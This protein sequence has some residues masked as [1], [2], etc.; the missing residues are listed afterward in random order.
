[1]LI[2]DLITAKEIAS[3]YAEVP[4]NKLPYLGESLFPAVKQDGIDIKWF[5]SADGLPL[6]ITPSNYD[7][8]ATL[9]DRAG[10]ASVETEMPFFREAMRI[11]EKERQEL[12]KFATQPTSPYVKTIVARLY[13]DVAKL[14]EGVK[15]QAE[16]MRMQLLSTG[17]ISIVANGVAYDYDY[18]FNANH[19]KTLTGTAKWSDT[20]NADPYADIKLALDTVEADTGVRPDT[21]IMTRKSFD[22]LVANAK[23]KENLFFVLG[24]G[25]VAGSVV[26]T[27]EMVKQYLRLRLQIDVIIYNKKFMDGSTAKS[28]FPDD[29]VTFIPAQSKL[30]N[31]YFGVTPEESDLLSGNTD[32]QVAIVNNGVAVTTFKEVHPVNV[33]TVVSAIFL[34]SFEGIETTYILTLA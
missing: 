29:V 28:Y 14:V 24:G 27:D 8:K 9:R 31:T 21:A 4:S 16:R 33:V 3:F 15:V 32:A 12:N 5:K 34:P 17:K 23:I 30:G 10:F 6:A 26:V 20:A 2:F 22:Y 11:G 7:A 13:A 25:S 19:K 1:M 18:K